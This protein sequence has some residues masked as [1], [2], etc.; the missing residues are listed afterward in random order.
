MSTTFQRTLS[1]VESDGHGRSLVLSLSL[2]LLLGAGVSWLSLSRVNVYVTSDLA[3]VEVDLS[4]HPVQ[5]SL[6]GSVVWTSAVRLG[7][8]VEAGTP[9]V[10][11]DPMPRRIELA[12]ARAICEARKRSIEAQHQALD[13]E[14]KVLVRDARAANAAVGAAWARQRAAKGLAQVA[15]ESS[16]IAQTL[17]DNALL[18]QHELLRERSQAQERW[19]AA[20]SLESEAVSIDAERKV[21]LNERASSI[22]QRKVLIAELEAD[23]AECDGDQKRL[24]Y[25]IGQHTIRAPVSGVIAELVPVTPGAELATGARFAAIVP[26]GAPRV[27]AELVPG[28]SVGRVRPGQRVRFA[29]DGFPWLQYGFVEG[30]VTHIGS[31][32]RG[33][34]I[35]VECALREHPPGLTLE[36]GLPGRAEIIVEAVSPFTLLLRAA[37]QAALDLEE[38]APST[39]GTPDSAGAPR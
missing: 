11:L 18:S 31:E 4:A 33:G 16:R 5:V 22:D 28:P 32:P 30:N 34:R 38:P 10:E 1:A 36:H 14:A 3:R 24:E 8:R 25:E 15:D 39:P 20:T 26:S 7:D 17:H 9:L 27:V 2:A 21:R 19:G 35:R 29:L 37:G 23:V 6:G 13:A 12:R